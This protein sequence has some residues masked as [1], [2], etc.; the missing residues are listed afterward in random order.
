MDHQRLA[1]CD[2]WKSIARRKWMAAN[3]IDQKV[4]WHRCKSEGATDLKKGKSVQ[5]KKMTA[6]G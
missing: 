2:A 3:T 6:D 5:G 4:K 1:E